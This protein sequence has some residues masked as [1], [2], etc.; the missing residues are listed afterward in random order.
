M[1][2]KEG[3][4]LGSTMKRR[5]MIK[6]MINITKEEMVMTTL[7]EMVV[8]PEV[9]IILEEEGVSENLGSNMI[10]TIGIKMAIM[11]VIKLRQRVRITE[12]K[13]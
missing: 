8:E 13:P 5:S 11:N 12:L 6:I 7:E 4:K 3:M 9:E 2:V 10:I 1:E